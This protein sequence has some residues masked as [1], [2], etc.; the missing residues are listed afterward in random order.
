MKSRPAC[1]AINLTPLAVGFLFGPEQCS[2]GLPGPALQR[3]L[4]ANCL[5]TERGNPPKDL[6][7]PI[8]LE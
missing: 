7:N 8:F 4:K 6:P 5:E 1:S 2:L 3:K